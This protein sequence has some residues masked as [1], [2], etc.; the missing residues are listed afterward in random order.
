M[1]YL[2][3]VRGAFNQVMLAYH[4]WSLPCRE[5]FKTFFSMFGE[6]LNFRFLLDCQNRSCQNN[7]RLTRSGETCRWFITCKIDIAFSPGLPQK[8]VGQLQHFQNIAVTFFLTGMKGV[9]KPTS[10]SLVELDCRV[11][12]TTWWEMFW[13]QQSYLPTHKNK[14][15][16]NQDLSLSSPKQH[17]LWFNCSGKWNVSWPRSDP[18]TIG[19]Q[20]TV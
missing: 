8:T 18:T 13:I 5:H 12:S 2:V 9:S 14:H 15:S 10:I 17:L 11:F 16:N 20:R 3:A 19:V 4:R 6:M 1:V 7:L